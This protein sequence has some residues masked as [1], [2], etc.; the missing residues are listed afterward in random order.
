MNG[1]EACLTPAHT[2][3]GCPDSLRLAQQWLRDG[4]GG[5]WDLP[6]PQL[7][8]KELGPSAHRALFPLPWALACLVLCPRLT[9]TLYS[10]FP[11]SSVK[12]LLEASR[13]QA[14]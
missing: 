7:L 6:Q 13:L 3:L 9:Q 2:Q 14:L 4:A 8:H 5:T 12:I 10:H 11:K 1:S